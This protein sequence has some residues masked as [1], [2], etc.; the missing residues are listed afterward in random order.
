MEVTLGKFRR[1]A[2]VLVLLVVAPVYGKELSSSELSQKVS[3]LEARIA[4][5]EQLVATNSIRLTLRAGGQS[6][7]E[8]YF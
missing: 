2:A 6:R 5:L 7:P 3:E 8:L 4:G 1:L